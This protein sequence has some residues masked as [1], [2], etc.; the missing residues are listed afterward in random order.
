MSLPLEGKTAIITGSSRGIGK[1]LALQLA[2]D[3][4]NIVVCARSEQQ[5]ELPGTIGETARELTALGREAL[6]VKLDLASDHDI[7]NGTDPII[8]AVV[9]IG[10][11]ES[12]VDRVNAHLDA[13]ADH[14]CIQVRAERSND[15]SIAAYRELAAAFGL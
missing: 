10:D 3:G 1:M 7:E 5:G 13:G 15:P 11:V 2:Q 4:A 8:D 12:I 9:V 6:A 14:V